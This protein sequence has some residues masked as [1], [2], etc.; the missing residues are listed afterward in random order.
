MKTLKAITFAVLFATLFSCGEE[1]LDRPPLA[2]LTVGTFPESEEDAV[3]A[4]NA[5]YNILRS[6][7]FHAGGFPILDIMSDQ[8]TKGTNPGDGGSTAPFEDFSFDPFAGQISAWWATVYSGIRRA[9]LVIT[10]VPSIDMDEELRTRLVAEARFLRGYSYSVLVRAF[11]A[12]P[13]VTTVDAPLDL[14]R[15]E[16]ETV[17]SE[18]IFPDLE[19]A[20][21][22]LPEKSEYPDAD[23]GRVTKG[24]TKALLA[25]LYL[26]RGE[27]D[28]AE[29]M[30]LEVINSGQYQ[31]EPNFGDAFSEDFEG[32]VESIW[33]IPALPEN[34]ANGGNQYANTWAI[35][36][37]P[38]RGW[39]FGRPAYSWITMMQA[40][41]D[42]RMDASVIFLGEVLDGVVTE[43]EGPT[44]DTTYNEQGAII[45]IEVYNQKV[46]HSGAATQESF[47][48]NK[49]NIRYADVLLMA[50]EALNENGKSADALPY[51][52]EVRER[53]R[54]GNT[55][56]LPDIST[57]DQAAL[58]QIIADERN[59]ELA[60][61][62]L[63]FWDLIRTGKAAEV[64]GPLG[65]V[66]GKHQLLPIPQS[67]IDISE[68]RISQNDNY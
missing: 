40:N 6:W 61:E 42:P 47:G 48:H 10:E 32:G 67:E 68:G 20:L 38:N 12:V 17:W 22:H 55:T 19:Y 28:L 43:G 44:P 51:L 58:R 30:A 60:F 46:W 41:D 54:G 5:V 11:G 56:I 29:T 26:F 66:D 52:N 33:E 18:V 57:T 34:N 21:E 24:A 65:F 8:A 35:R 36:G 45:E 16:A 31:L 27:F 59:F 1:F 49:R 9:N 53:A 50:A 23:L 37:T 7:N 39:G 2:Q 63:R 14:S 4:T 3:L 62:G 64:M 13:L 25:R 15:T